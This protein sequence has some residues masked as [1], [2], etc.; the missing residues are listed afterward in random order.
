MYST[1]RSTNMVLIQKKTTV[2]GQYNDTTA[3]VPHCRAWVSINP[4]RGREITSGGE[5]ISVVTH[6]IRG[7]Y[8]AL[9]GV[10]EAMRV[11]HNE[12]HAYDS[13]P[14]NS[15]VYNIHAVMADE[16][17]HADVMIQASRDNRPYGLLPADRPE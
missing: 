4:V 10:T 17:R 1:R 5:Q 12:T 9:S 11:V 2:A 8:V 14:D 16:D 7:D 3:W 15:V 13:I 6:T